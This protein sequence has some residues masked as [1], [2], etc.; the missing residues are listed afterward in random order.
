MGIKDLSDFLKTRFPQIFKTVHISEYSF[1][2]VA[3]DISLYMNI[4]IHRFA[5]K[6]SKPGEKVI[7]ECRKQDWIPGFIDLVATLRKNEVHCVFVYDSKAPIEK[8]LE[9][10][11]RCASKDKME[12]NVSDLISE[13]DTYY[14]T[15]EIS[16][17]L[18]DFQEKKNLGFKSLLASQK[19]L[20]IRGIEVALENMLKNL[21]RPQKED[22]IITKK[23]FDLLDI[24]YIDADMEAET[25][26]SDLC[27]Q[28]KIEAVLS[29]DTD[30]LAYAAP[31]F[32]TDINTKNQTCTMIEYKELLQEMELSSDEFLDFCI[33]CGTDYN[34]NIPKVGP[35]KAYSL[36]K[37]FGSIENIGK[38]TSFDISILNHKRVRELFRGYPKYT[39]PVS[40]CGIPKFDEL[41]KFLTQLNI[42]MD[43]DYLEQS[44]V[45][46][47]I[48]E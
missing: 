42:K 6:T 38:Q 12:N 40:Y 46:K 27:L 25:L 15:K 37:E 34:K 7:V 44:F 33:L 30:V 21:V 4:F 24:P 29:K 14:E 48:I 18:F 28:G 9:K 45:R 8:Q 5:R 2:K 20:N 35:V 41:E 31:I 39:K 10:E 11:K 19:Q 43:H 16:K 3:I 32:L 22:Y 1:K 47:F 23:L 13:L 26:C 36:I 17:F